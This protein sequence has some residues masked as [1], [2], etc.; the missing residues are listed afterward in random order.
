MSYSATSQVTVT[1]H[2]DAMQVLSKPQLFSNQV[3]QHLSVPN[4]M[5]DEQHQTYR[6]LIE[7]FFSTTAI[8]QFQPACRALIERQIAALVDHADG[9]TIDFITAFARPF[10]LDIQWLFMGWPDDYKPLIEA[11]LQAQQQAQRQQDKS[12][13]VMLAAEFEQHIATLAKLAQQQSQPTVMRQLTELRIHGRALSLAELTSLIRNWTV[14]ELATITA[15]VGLITGYLAQHPQ[16]QQ[17]L[18]NNDL[19]LRESIDEILRIH[20]PLPSNRRRTRCPVQLA[21]QEL[22]SATPIT[23]VWPEIQRD[24]AVFPQ[25]LTFNPQQN[26]AHNLLY[27]AGVHVCPGKPLAQLEL[28]TFTRIL[29]ERVSCLELAGQPTWSNYPATGFSSLP[30]RLSA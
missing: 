10:A 13:M 3:S 28:E 11:W 24:A 22:P 23:L 6:Q 30:L 1:C 15:S 8:A 16:L 12:A 4:G 20:A 7:P 19:P 5:D 27:G 29:L 21:Q 17:Q 14:G 2:A 26:A 25:P 18:R 9:M